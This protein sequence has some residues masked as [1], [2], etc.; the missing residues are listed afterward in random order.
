MSHFMPHGHCILWNPTLLTLHVLSD[1]I[2]FLSYFSIPMAIWFYVKKKGL[3]SYLIP[4]LFISFI[5]SC[6]ITHIFTI[7]N[8]WHADYWLAG[9]MKAICAL[10]S[11]V[12]AVCLWILMPKFLRIPTTKDLAEVNFNL[13][14]LNDELEEKVKE[15]TSSLEELNKRLEEKNTQKTNFLASVSH[16]V[17]NYLNIINTSSELLTIR[18][19]PEAKVVEMHNLITKSGKELA[20]I[21]EDI[22]DLSKIESGTYTVEKRSF[23]LRSL[24]EDMANL[25]KLRTKRKNLDFVF[26][27]DESLPVFIM[28]DEGRVKQILINL[29]SN[30]VKYTEK[31]TIYFE[32]TFS[33]DEIIFRIKDSGSGIPVEDQGRIFS[34]FMRSQI[35]QSV[36]GVGLGL[37][38]S[39][40]IASFLEGKIQ[41]E[42]SNEKGTCFSFKIPFIKGQE[43]T[44][45]NY[46][47]TDL[48]E[49]SEKRILI[50]DDAKEN[51]MLYHIFLE[52]TH[53]QIDFAFNGKE[54][55]EL[56]SSNFYDLIILDIEM[57][58]LNGIEAMQ[59]I[60]TTNEV[61]P[62][63]ALTAYA[64]KSSYESLI[65]HGFDECISKPVDLS[66][67]IQVMGSFL[68]G[69]DQL[70]VE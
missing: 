65:A 62:I 45:S 28:S 67:L 46:R 35:H 4:G 41:L 33:Q 26:T 12:T 17:R 29:L 32:T 50:A 18:K 22:L 66:E 42:Y 5:L 24:V 23:S 9:T 30:A 21:I 2:I 31:G 25:Y 61:V 64:S 37:S 69:E 6:G 55:V 43:I 54:A 7:W 1:F 60:K 47:R 63:M 58:E 27:Y 15:R 36:E 10:I 53:V 49:W 40:Q 59:V 56:A 70:R 68:S 20:R 11:S 13:K 34:H 44:R 57:P 16:E 14:S 38:L 39:N 48:P 51:R 52:P 8:W 19:L 3:K